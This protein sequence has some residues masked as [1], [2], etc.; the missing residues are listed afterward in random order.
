[1]SLKWSHVRTK[2]NKEVHVALSTFLTN[3]QIDQKSS[4]LTNGITKYV[5]GNW[6][7][8]LELKRFKSF[9]GLG[10]K[11]KL[12]KDETQSAMVWWQTQKLKEPSSIW[13]KGQRDTNSLVYLVT[14]LGMGAFGSLTFFSFFSIFSICFTYACNFLSSRDSF[15]LLL[16]GRSLLPTSN[17]LS[18]ESVS[19]WKTGRC[20]ILQITNTSFQLE[21][22]LLKSGQYKVRWDTKEGIPF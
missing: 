16:I 13:G 9:A 18:S 6:G 22:I 7:G 15:F 4:N 17:S 10:K 1:M 3:W 11:N 2:V 20:V 12:L 8:S 19:P 21:Y 14:H 5:V